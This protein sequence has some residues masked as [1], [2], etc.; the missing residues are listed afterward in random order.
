MQQANDH[1]VV[2]SCRDLG[3]LYKFFFFLG[4]CNT[5]KVDI[6]MGR[7]LSTRCFLTGDDPVRMRL[8]VSS[9]CRLSRHWDS[10]DAPPPKKRK[11]PCSHAVVAQTHQYAGLSPARLESADDSLESSRF[12]W[13]ASWTRKSV[14]AP[15][16][17]VSHT[18]H[19]A[20]GW[21][22]S[23]WTP[24]WMCTSQST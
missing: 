16:L 14:S 7:P 17:P 18:S 12:R 1:H 9:Y 22:T 6:S 24:L 21:L 13:P 2:A 8:Q 10:A 4:A 15:F 11:R 3:L 5:S 20:A 19:G 23:I